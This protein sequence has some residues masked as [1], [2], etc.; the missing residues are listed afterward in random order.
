M[1]R[2]LHVLLEGEPV[3][4]IEERSGELELTY[5]PS[6]AARQDAYPLSLSMPLAARNH[7]EPVRTF[8]WGLLPDNDAILERWGQR[9]G[10]SPRNPFR[11][12]AHVGEDCAGAMQLVRP[13]RL[14]AVEPEQSGIDWIEEGEVSERLLRLREDQSATRLPNDT[15]QFS[16]AGA[17]PKLAL[18]KN[19]GRWGVPY[20]AVPTTHILK[21]SLPDLSGHAM[22]EHQTLELARALGL[23][24]ARSELWGDPSAE[25]IVVERF[26]RVRQGPDPQAIRRVHQEDLC[27]AFGM[28]PARKYQNE[29]GP[30]PRAIAELL[31]RSSSRAVEDVERFRDALLFHWLT[32]GTDAHAKNYSLL[33]GPGGQVRLAPLYDVASVLPFD[34]FEERRLRLAMKLGRTYRLADVRRGDL[35]HLASDL[36]L[37]A[38][39]T[40]ERALVMAAGIH[41][42]LASLSGEG[43]V[44]ERLVDMLAKRA[45]RCAGLLR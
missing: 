14:E 1:T 45:T 26:D 20:G 8:L 39:S 41:E 31:R 34:G 7:R 5:D 43:E 13:E 29:G 40:I 18:L 21:P 28:H 44:F 37:G 36:S 23:R 42:A 3:A 25:A 24:A 22:V 17:Q 19:D 35:E 10:V 16:L 6:W 15:G 4:V 30:G 32:A 11:L 38:R 2:V 9:F 12:L 33:H 27:Q